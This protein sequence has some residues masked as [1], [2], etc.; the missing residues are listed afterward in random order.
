MKNIIAGD[1]FSLSV[2]MMTS[3]AVAFTPQVSIYT[4]ADSNKLV[5]QII[6][7]DF[8]SGSILNTNLKTFT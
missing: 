1:T 4:Y 2:E 8:S 5:D 3:T 6:N 7:T